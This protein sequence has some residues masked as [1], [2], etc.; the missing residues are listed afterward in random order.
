MTLS[1]DRVVTDAADPVASPRDVRSGVNLDDTPPLP[2]RRPFAGR[3][4]RAAR[5]AAT[6]AAIGRVR[7][8]YARL[9]RRRR[10][11]QPQA[12]RRRPPLAGHAARSRRPVG[13]KLLTNPF[14][15][16]DQP[17]LTQSSGWLDAWRSSPSAYVVAAESAADVAAAVRFARAHNL[18]LVVKGGGHS[19][20]GGSNAPDSLLIWTRRWTPSPSTTPSRRRAPAPRRS[21]R[22]RCGAGC[23]WLHAYQAVTGGAG[24]Y[25]QGGGC[26]TVGV[27]GPGAGRRLRQLLQGL[28]H[29]RRQPAGG[30]D[31]HRRRP[32]PRRQPRARTRPLLGAEGRRRRHVRRRHPR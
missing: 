23:M 1:A 12:G 16:G 10:L 31:R 8:G 4:R 15:I 27:A 11:G 13:R 22:S 24:R 20:L 19:Y 25:V 32:G 7:P 29:G 30:R 21:R 28:R 2:G 17:G 9:A 14:Y 26:T 6:A 18:R 5:R 3:R